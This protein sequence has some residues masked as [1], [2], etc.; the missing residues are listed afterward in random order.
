[1]TRESAIAALVGVMMLG[2]ADDPEPGPA[3]STEAPAAC[4][5]AAEPALDL[6]EFFFAGE[7]PSTSLALTNDCPTP[8]TLEGLAW[9]SAPMEPSFE[10]VD[11]PSDGVTL[12]V[13]ERLSVEV[14]ARAVAYGTLEDTL[15]ITGATADGPAAVQVAV[16]AVAVCKGVAIDVDDDGDG[17][18]NGCDAC[19]LGDDS[20]DAD[21]DTVPDACDFCPDAD[22]LADADLDGNPDGCDLCPEH[23]DLL[24]ADLDGRPDGCDVCPDGDDDADDDGDTVPD[25]CEVC[26]G[27]DDLLDADLDTIPDGCDVCAGGD[28]RSDGDGDF[29]PDACDVCSAGDDA[30]DADGDTVPDACDR[31]PG[32]DDTVDADGDTVPDPCDVCDGG[33]D[34]FD[35]DFDGVPD[36]C[37][38]PP[39]R[40]TSG[41]GLA[42]VWQYVAGPHAFSD[43]RIV[44]Q[45]GRLTFASFVDD[46]GDGRGEVEVFGRFGPAGATQCGI[47]G[48]WIERDQGDVWFELDVHAAPFL[49]DVEA[50]DDVL[51][52]ERSFG[53]TVLQRVEEIP[54]PVRCQY[55]TELDRF[56]IPLQGPTGWLGYDGTDLYVQNRDVLYTVSFTQR[57]L[58]ASV[59]LDKVFDEPLAFRGPGL[60][61]MRSWLRPEIALLDPV[62]YVATTLNLA[63]ELG[64]DPSLRAAATDGG[65]MFLQGTDGHDPRLV[66]IDLDASPPTALADVPSESCFD[67]MVHDGDLWCV[68]YQHSD[69]VLVQIDPASGA[70]VRTVQLPDA[71]HAR[72]IVGIGDSVF[73]TVLRGFATDIVEYE[74]PPPRSA[75]EVPESEV[76]PALAIVAT[77]PSLEILPDSRARIRIEVERPDLAGDVEV[78]VHGLP[79]EVTAD[80]VTLGA[81]VTVADVWLDATVALARDQS[82]SSITL[83]VTDG[84]VSASTTVE[85]RFAATVPPGG[86]ADA[87]SILDLPVGSGAQYGGEIGIDSRGRRVVVTVDRDSGTYASQLHRVRPDGTLDPT[88]GVAGTVQLAD[89]IVS[90]LVV[91][92][93]DE[94]VVS[95]TDAIGQFL[96]R[97]DASGAEVGSFSANTAPVLQARGSGVMDTFLDG[98]ALVYADGELVRR[99]DL[100]GNEDASARYEA[101][102]PGSIVAAAPDGAGGVYVS[103][104]WPITYEGPVIDRIDATGALDLSFGLDGRLTMP[105]DLYHDGVWRFVP[106]D[107]GGAIALALVQHT[108]SS[109][110]GAS[111][112]RFDADGIVDP[113][114][115]G[116]GA[117]ETLYGTWSP[118]P[119]PMVRIGDRIVVA[120][121]PQ[122][123][124]APS[125]ARRYELDGTP[126]PTFGLTEMVDLPAW[127]TDMAFDPLHDELV[128]VILH[129][130]AGRVE[131]VQIPL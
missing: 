99:F 78:S 101:E 3:P 37:D 2:C 53:R 84:P 50:G 85:L 120:G 57:T 14:R 43:P 54:D 32:A 106:T 21:G 130:T 105:T 91:L 22:D 83:T 86:V 9:A 27:S 41:E 64:L 8:V 124:E 96:E 49:A 48:R 97:Y 108:P 71:S 100:D 19:L 24:D 65:R 122:L 28:D 51:A 69:T 90:D 111:L 63:S 103:L 52:I 77:P 26:W 104:H 109:G 89:A 68:Q 61:A 30:L 34:R 39:P 98:D 16:S 119:P 107:D 131:L 17:I 117:V 93:G 127:P 35:G 10:L 13:G 74:L 55:A 76:A 121:A 113:T 56:E 70:T 18:P 73:A 110:L 67:L 112:S 114:F 1:M 126:D 11:P 125:V 6:G 31:C 123:E 80:D 116:D 40:P 23:D 20:E 38:T 128:A 82:P 75:P 12:P 87:V 118:F 129:K 115:G 25:A 4:L 88:F 15:E 46:D 62:P 59:A 5:T 72:G 60:W 29:V 92:P 47:A 58:G 66:T 44:S 45:W 79:P 94:L 102:I 7:A 33:D 42:G 95:G 81:D 36:A